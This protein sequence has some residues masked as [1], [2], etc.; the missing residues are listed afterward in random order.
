M[1]QG[2]ISLLRIIP[3]HKRIAMTRVSLTQ[4]V[5]DGRAGGKRAAERSSSELRHCASPNQSQSTV[6]H[7]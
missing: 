2:N 7:H 3:K 4:T 6:W 1:V 5:T